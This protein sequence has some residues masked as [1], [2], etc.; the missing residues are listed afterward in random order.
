M[1]QQVK[2][3]W[4]LFV[5]LVVLLVFGAFYSGLF[6]K[7]VRHQQVK[8]APQIG[9]PTFF[10]HG[11]GSSYH[12]EEYMVNGAIKEGILQ[13]K[14]VIVA[15]VSPSGKVKLSGKLA[16]NTPHPV[17]EVNY[18]NSRNG[19]YRADG[20][21]ARNV[22]VTV[23]N[24]YRFKRM[25]LVG[26]SMGNQDIAYYLLDNASDKQ[27]PILNKE[28]ALAAPFNG[29]VMDDHNK[30]HDQNKANGQPLKMPRSYKELLKLR[31]TYPKTAEVLNIYGN[32][33]HGTDGD[34]TIQSAQ[35]M[36]YLVSGRAKSYQEVE[37]KG[38]QAS[39]SR[40]HHNE[41]V[42]HLLYNFLWNHAV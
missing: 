34:L 25:N 24:H 3:R 36:K 26:H 39:H 11:Y 2:N 42:N 37:M 27:L 12:A 1:K 38:K 5:V 17:I 22:I 4:W 14:D 18:E 35:S 33:G 28:V 41:D 29:L 9:T 10:F 13:K 31:Q 23:Q 6:S 20:Q 21:W 32:K 7:T 15:H 19:D 16:A 40:L 30:N 8:D